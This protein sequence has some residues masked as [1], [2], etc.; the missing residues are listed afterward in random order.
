MLFGLGVERPPVEAAP[1]RD[2]REAGARNE[3]GDLGGT[4][5]AVGELDAAIDGRA[6]LARA[7][8]AVVEGRRQQAPGEPIGLGVFG[9]A[10][11]RGVLEARPRPR[12]S[13]AK[14]M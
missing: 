13:C 2:H 5:Q 3:A 1:G 14:R 7:H 9:G 8:S 11:G 12:S 4:E 10:P 6:P